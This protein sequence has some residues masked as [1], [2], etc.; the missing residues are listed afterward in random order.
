MVRA[1]SVDSCALMCLVSISNSQHLLCHLSLQLPSYPFIHCSPHYTPIHTPIHN[2]IHIPIHPPIHTPIHPPIHNPIH[3]PIPISI[4]TPISI[5]IH[6]P[7]H[8]PIHAHTGS[9]DV[10][11]LVLLGNIDVLPSWLERNLLYLT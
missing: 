2:P 4:H 3:A 5:T 11:L 1:W 9:L 8:T 7:I 6:V 10:F